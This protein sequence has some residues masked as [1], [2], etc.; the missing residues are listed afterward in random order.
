MTERRA[1]LEAWIEALDRRDKTQ[2]DSLRQRFERLLGPD[3]RVGEAYACFDGGFTFVVRPAVDPIAVRLTAEGEIVIEHHVTWGY[4][5]RQLRASIDP[6]E[7]GLYLEG[8][9]RGTLR[10]FGFRLQ[11]PEGD[12]P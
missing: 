6:T 5:E 1:R 7:P 12:R 4:P 8:R 10:G 2:V 9:L 3:Y 11:D